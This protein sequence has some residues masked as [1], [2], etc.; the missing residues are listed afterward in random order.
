MG[1][2]DRDYHRELPYDGAPGLHLGGRTLTTNL[3][4]LMGVVYVVQLLT[5]PSGAMR[6]DVGW[7]TELFSL[8][9]DLPRRPWLAF[10]LVTYGFL[11]NVN[12]IKHILFNALAFWIFGRSVEH[13]YGRREYLAFFLAAIMVAGIAWILG[14]F[15]AGRG[16][17]NATMLGASGGIAGVLLLFCLN[18]PRQQVFIWALFPIP[19]WLFAVLFLGFDLLGAVR[20]Q[21]SN[22]AYTAHLGGAV[23]AYLYYRWGLHLERWL[24]SGSWRLPWRRRP[25]LRVHDAGRYDQQEEADDQVDQ[26]LRKIQQQGQ[27]SLTRKE[28]RILEQASRD[29]QKKKR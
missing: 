24:P 1:I 3:V 28:R 2:Y 22:V 29:Y 26:I 10:E 20:Q 5:E 21:E 17:S 7:F 11:H 25:R 15:V 27:D 6:G 4:I 12:D 14:E 18:F 8:H 16:L 19:A 9:A 23:F 13:R